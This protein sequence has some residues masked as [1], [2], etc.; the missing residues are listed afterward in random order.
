[1]TV[2]STDSECRQ[3]STNEDTPITMPVASNDE[4]NDGGNTFNLRI[5]NVQRQ[6]TE[7]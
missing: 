6:Q 3:H 1:M 7:R 4:M 5:L 2:E